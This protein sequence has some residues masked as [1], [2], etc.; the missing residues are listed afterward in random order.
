MC[1]WCDPKKT[2][3]VCNETRERQFFS[4]REWFR[5]KKDTRDGKCLSCMPPPKA[6]KGFRTCRMCSKAKDV[7]EFTMWTVA[8]GKTK[9]QPRCNECMQQEDMQ[10]QTLRNRNKTDVQVSTDGTSASQLD[11]NPHVTVFCSECHSSQPI[12]MNLFWKRGNRSN[13]F[14]RWSCTT[15][16]CSQKNVSLGNWLLCLQ[17]RRTSKI[18]T[19]MKA[20]RLHDHAARPV[21]ITNTEDIRRVITKLETQTKKRKADK[22]QMDSESQRKRKKSGT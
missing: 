12:D 18:A 1:R 5:I 8:H 14:V 15:D 9:R 20:S 3:S 11:M 21:H 7:S 4:D 6:Q 17:N 13:R 22:V 19:W 2:C 10:K 16:V